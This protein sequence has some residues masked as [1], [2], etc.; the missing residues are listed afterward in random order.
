MTRCTDPAAEQG[1]YWELLVDGT[2]VNGGVAADEESAEEEARLAYQRY[3]GHR[4]YTIF[5]EGK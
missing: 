1:W 2:R 5:E 3:L 4:H